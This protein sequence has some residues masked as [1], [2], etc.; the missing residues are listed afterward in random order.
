MTFGQTVRALQ[1]VDLE[2]APREFTSLI[3]PS[4]CG[5]STLLRMVGGLETASTGL[6]RLEGLP[7]GPP[8]RRRGMVFQSYSSFP[9]LTVAGNV[10]F[11]MRYRQDLGGA[12]K[13][14]RAQHYL[15]LVGLSD[16]AECEYVASPTVSITASTRSGSRAPD[17]NA[18]CAPSSTALA[19]FASLRA[20]AHTR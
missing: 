3:G 15:R 19:C 1:D 5:K 7:V 6:I 16:F 9:W 4:G 10:L 18:S 12:E 11:G 13:R 8:D 14:E 2:V 17:G 20:V